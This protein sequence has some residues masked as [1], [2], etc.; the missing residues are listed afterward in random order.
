[1]GEYIENNWRR[2]K[3]LR[4]RRFRKPY[5]V[6]IN[7]HNHLMPSNVFKTY[8]Y[9]I[10]TFIPK[11]LFE[12]Y[13]KMSIL[14]FTVVMIVQLVPSISPLIPVTSILPLLFV[15]GLSMAREGL[16]D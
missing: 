4:P 14:Y 8:K 10:I 2:I 12:Q 6:K 15:L 5:V 1:M 13:C 11:S 3:W 16:E 9:N 7:E